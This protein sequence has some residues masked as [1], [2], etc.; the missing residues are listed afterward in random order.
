METSALLKKNL[1]FFTKFVEVYEKNISL[2]EK[3]K[4]LL[5]ERNEL[6]LIE[7]I[8]RRNK[9]KTNALSN[10]DDLYIKKKRYRRGKKD[11]LRTFICKYPQCMKKYGTEG[12]LNQ[13]IKRKHH[14]QQ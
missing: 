3:L 14:G 9:R 13:H 7:R 5:K 8:D 4:I 2:K 11:I 10:V 6:H 1:E 12:S